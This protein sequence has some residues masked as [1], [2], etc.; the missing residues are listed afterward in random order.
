MTTGYPRTVYLLVYYIP[1]PA[2]FVRTMMPDT[3]LIKPRTHLPNLPGRVRIPFNHNTII[4]KL[5]ICL[6][7]NWAYTYC[8]S[9]ACLLVYNEP[10]PAYYVRKMMPDNELNQE[11]MCL[12]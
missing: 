2:Y 12:D 10:L 6:Y 4:F 11:L 3:E 8:Y 5:C 9:T 1:L 7:E